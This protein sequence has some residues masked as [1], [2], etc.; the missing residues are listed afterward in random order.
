M[1]LLAAMIGCIVIAMKAPTEGNMAAGKPVNQEQ[2]YPE[3]KPV[4][5][6]L[7]TPAKEM[8]EIIK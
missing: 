7:T 8:E 6:I 5:K 3:I 1:L 2:K 4:A